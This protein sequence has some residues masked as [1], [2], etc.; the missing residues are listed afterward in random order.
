MGNPQDK[1]KLNINK[2]SIHVLYCKRS[3]WLCRRYKS[4]S[5]I[6]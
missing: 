6:A 3:M 5:V 1:A 2:L 4:G